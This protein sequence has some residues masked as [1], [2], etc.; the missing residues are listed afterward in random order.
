M[1]IKQKLS[2]LTDEQIERFWKHLL[3]FDC[4][5]IDCQNCLFTYKGKC[6]SLTVDDEYFARINNSKGVCN[7]STYS[8]K[9]GNR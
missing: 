8:S 7:D 9:M 6:L 3:G 4:S 5:F 2:A 1:D